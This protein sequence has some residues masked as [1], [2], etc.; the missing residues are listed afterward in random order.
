MRHLTLLVHI[1]QLGSLTRVAASLN[2]SQPATT[3]ALAEVEGI[4]GAPLFTRTAR[5]MHPTS[6]GRLVVERAGH[7][8]KDL[9]LWTQEVDALRAGQAAH[10][11][12]GAVPYV[13]A[14]LLT[15]AISALY[16][17]HNVTL[18]LHRATTDQLLDLLQRRELDCVIGRASSIGDMQQYTHKVLYRQLPAL[19]A[20]PRL[21]ERMA[22]REPDW[23]ALSRMNWVLPSSSTPTR[24]MLTEHFIRAD[25]RP[26]I[27]ILETFSSDVVEGMLSS[28]D[29]LLSIVPEELALEMCRRGGVAI[30]PWG[31]DW[32]LPP[33]SLIRRVREM[34]LAAEGQLTDILV[35]LCQPADETF[36]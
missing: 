31:F 26:P 10:L 34:P 8:L 17:R 9:E 29:T 18:S 13:S 24:Q 3:K 20:H 19:I 32:E 25:A 27:P 2:I 1:A 16:G 5:G 36:P 12:V 4:F 30:V 23:D 7:M 14:S 11:M 28:N 21:A 15:R 22:R 35:E 33:L 6:L